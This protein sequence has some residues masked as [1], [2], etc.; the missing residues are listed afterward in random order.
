MKKTL[1]TFAVVALFGAALAPPAPAAQGAIAAADRCNGQTIGDASAH[2]AYYDRHAPS[3]KPAELEKRYGAIADALSTLREEQEVLQN[4]CTDDARLASL[5]A[6]IAATAAWGLALQSDLAVK[7]NASCP[8]AAKGLP[9][10]MLADAWLSLAK[11]VNDDGGTV[12]KAIAGAAPKVQSRAAAVGLT[13]P[14]WGDTSQYWRDQISTQA[15][16]AIATCP[17]P[18]APAPT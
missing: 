4:V 12:P 1:F 13:L 10:M 18:P 17:S 14:V 8:A 16:A 2:I 9:T 7:M 3:N 11:V 6:D 15:K 5:T